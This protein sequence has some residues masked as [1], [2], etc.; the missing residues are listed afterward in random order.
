MVVER[1]IKARL[2]KNL[3]PGKVN[4]VYG[5]RRVGKT[6]LIK[7][8][9]DE[10]NVNYLWLNGELPE[11]Q[12]I[13]EKKNLN[14]YRN[15]FAG[16]EIIIID[17]AQAINDIGKILKIVVDELPHLKIIASGS[18][19]FDLANNL[20]EPL[21]GRA[22]W[23]EMYP[24]AQLEIAN[25]ENFFET[26]RRKEERLIYGSY[27]EIYTLEGF[28]QKE[29]Y[30]RDLVNSYLLKD[31]LILDG[32]RNSSKIYD[33]LKLIAFQ[34]GKEVSLNELGTQLGMSKNTIEKY[35]D[36]LEKVF[37]LKKIPGFS[38]NLRKEVTKSSRW[39]F[40]D[41]GI[42]NAVINDF[43]SLA[44]RND[45]GELWEN[46]L[47]MERLKKNGYEKNNVETYFWR[48]YDQ[49]EIDCIEVKNG[50][51]EAYEFKYSSKI[52][53]TPGGFAHAYPES[54]FSTVNKDNYLDFII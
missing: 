20:G 33:L 11:T 41:N 18:S 49:Q 22:F 10:L 52:A 37:V 40:W 36:L 25:S 28:E 47:M 31:I 2:L 6:F 45:T 53:K 29:E 35:L 50:E 39:F 46:Y 1:K 54:S 48:T 34:L 21:V 15:I 8:I 7:Q 27:P 26:A 32:V 17:E 51:I 3:I 9:A 13:L 24:L 4:V 12:E 5:A 14:E 16:F 38:K 23:H 43:K 42:R 44:F 19:A 30:L